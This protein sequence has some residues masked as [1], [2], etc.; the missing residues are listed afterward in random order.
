M[1]GIYIYSVSKIELTFFIFKFGL[2]K[3]RLKKIKYKLTQLHK[4]LVDHL[5]FL[6]IQFAIIYLNHFL[7]L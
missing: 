7:E 5:N 6:T 3:I 4:Y 2:F 1:L